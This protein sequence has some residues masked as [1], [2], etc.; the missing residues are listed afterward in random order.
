MREFLV[1]PLGRSKRQVCPID[2]GWGTPAKLVSGDPGDR[3]AIGPTSNFFARF[4][5]LAPSLSSYR[6]DPGVRS[7]SMTP[8]PFPN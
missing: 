6:I 7:L 1:L 8:F 4:D 5:L 3:V 2:W